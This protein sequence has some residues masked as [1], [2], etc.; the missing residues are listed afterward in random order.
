MF[1]A[2]KTLILVKPFSPTLENVKLQLDQ[3][4]KQENINIFVVENKSEAARFIKAFSP[5]LLV[6]SSAKQALI[7][8]Q[9][10]HRNI[11]TTGS[12]SLLILPKKIPEKVIETAE[13]FG[14]SQ[15]ITE[16]IPMK[17]ISFKL[18][19]L[20]NSMQV[21]N[22]ATTPIKKQ[23]V[24]T[25]LST[26]ET[27]N[28]LSGRHE[29][30]NITSLVKESDIEPTT[31]TTTVLHQEKCE[32]ENHGSF[33]YKQKEK[34]YRE[35]ADK[36]DQNWKRIDKTVDA[37]VQ[38]I[39]K[40][41]RVNAIKNKNNH[42]EDCI[43]YNNIYSE[44]SSLNAKYYK[45]EIPDGPDIAQSQEENN[46]LNHRRIIPPIPK[47]LNNI[48][49]ISYLYFL[50]KNEDHESEH[51][52]RNTNIILSYL[53]KIIRDKFEGETIFYFYQKDQDT[54]L[55]LDDSNNKAPSNRDGDQQNKIIER[56]KEEK[57]PTWSDKHFNE[58]KIDFVYPVYEGIEKLGFIGVTFDW[59]F[60]PDEQMI[61]EALLDT[62]RG[63]YI[64][65]ILKKIQ[66][67]NEK[68]AA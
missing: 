51:N 42:N 15:I 14:L 50:F 58:M 41:K 68:K 39:D 61:L 49:F 20:L 36:V 25:P 18:N 34:A 55:C 32:I 59:G 65:K 31:T 67:S 44:F 24:T 52:L 2:T 23:K 29:K 17:T 64:Q 7:F 30:Q 53:K 19:L 60:N 57:I 3:V 12:K 54:Y 40:K 35:H 45:H 56:W 28:V 46:L 33:N 9:S 38:R 5:I 1:A 11:K 8:L 21:K 6:F 4:K 43:D 10:L 13:N 62:T 22:A 47:G 16:P 27:D 63:L 66:S 48:I 37:I 26:N